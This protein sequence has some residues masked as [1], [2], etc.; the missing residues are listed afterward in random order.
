[1]ALIRFDKFFGERP[2]V[3][4][5]KLQLREATQALNTRL[6]NGVVDSMRGTL[7]RQAVSTTPDPLTIM[8]YNSS[9]W[10][11]WANYVNAVRSP[12]Q[13][14]P[15][16]RVFFTGFSGYPRVADNTR[17]TSGG[18]PP[19][20]AASLRLGVPAPTTAITATVGGTATDP[21]NDVPEDRV[22]TLCYVNSFGEEGPP[23]GASNTVSVYPG[24]YVD[25]TLPGNPG[26]PYDLTLQRIY[27]ANVTSGQRGAYLHAQDVSITAATY[28]DSL[29]SSQLGS[30]IPS[31]EWD[32]PPD[33]MIGLTS[34]PGGFLAAFR[35]NEVM[36]CEPGLPHAWPV[37]YRY[38][39]DF[40][41]VGLGV[42]GNTLVVMTD[43]Q[44]YL[45]NGVHPSQMAFTKTELLQSCVS[46]PGIVDMGTYV[47]YPSPDGLV[48]I[49]PSGPRIIT[50]SVFDRDAWDALNPSSIKAVLWEGLY[51]AF[52]NDGT[53][54][55]FVFNPAQ[56]DA[57][58]VFTDGYAV[59]G[60]YN[61]PLDDKT[62]VVHSNYI[63]EWDVGTVLPFTWQSRPV[64]LQKP[65]P[66]R[67]VQVLAETYPVTLTL[68]RDGKQQ[69]SLDIEDDRPVRVGNAVRGRKY[70]VKVQGTG[71][72]IYDIVCATTPAELMGV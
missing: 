43:G 9:T 67:V 17:V 10:L 15:Y 52:Y 54:K 57:G 62:Y 55:A 64:E 19:Y 2:G 20:P 29:T 41:V 30:E 60:L 39:I 68:Y 33:D 4:P 12:V 49:G 35:K 50:A 7:A 32:E 26:G 36:F 63:N 34:L 38:P 70:Q 23:V 1:M 45:A 72:K 65:A 42:I 51:L 46:A 66:I 21:I 16:D 71:S 22:Y 69:V 11:E 3:N 58:V 37:R 27:R 8:K 48:A 56:P 28:R 53:D 44:P 59:Y 14:D 6:W 13:N 31:T 47:I 5:N 40:N 24:Q 61:D 25:L 18:Q